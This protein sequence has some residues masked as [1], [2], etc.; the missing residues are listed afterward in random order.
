[1]TRQTGSPVEKCHLA[2]STTSKATRRQLAGSHTIIQKQGNDAHTLLKTINNQQRLCGG[3]ALNV[4]RKFARACR[5]AASGMPQRYVKH[6]RRN[7]G[8]TASN[9]YRSYDQCAR[10]YSFTSSSNF[11]GQRI[12]ITAI[13]R[14]IQR[15]SNWKF[16]HCEM[17]RKATFGRVVSAGHFN[18]DQ[19]MLDRTR[20]LPVSS[21]G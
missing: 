18:A 6:V 12:A 8:E 19:R 21:T 2:R 17:C 11:T 14:S 10:P 16:P 9:P 4:G 1:M 7:C 3:G 20:R 5:K 15:R 13:G